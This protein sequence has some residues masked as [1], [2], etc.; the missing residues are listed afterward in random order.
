MGIESTRL[1]IRVIEANPECGEGAAVIGEMRRDR[2]IGDS[3]GW[4]PL[5]EPGP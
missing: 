1:G 3:E 4:R 5:G 2:Y